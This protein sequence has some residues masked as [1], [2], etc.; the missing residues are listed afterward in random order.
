MRRKVLES[1]N[2]LVGKPCSEAFA[3]NSVVL[4]RVTGYNT[5]VR[6]AVETFGRC[7]G[8]KL[9]SQFT[10]YVIFMILQLQR[11]SLNTIPPSIQ[12]RH[13]IKLAMVSS[14]TS[15]LKP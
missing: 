6:Q 9:I 1:L 7:S 3:I 12:S 13:Y 2:I 10:V 5:P 14:H 8:L 11:Q 15:H 4:S